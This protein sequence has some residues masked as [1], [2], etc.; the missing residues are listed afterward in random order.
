MSARA[1]LRDTFRAICPRPLFGPLRHLDALWSR[2]FADST[3]VQR[4]L[5]EDCPAWH[6]RIN[7]VLA[8][9]D[10]EAIPRVAAAGEVRGGWVVMH[11]GIEVG[12]L[13]YYGSGILQMLVRNKGVHEPQEE[14]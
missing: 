13:T 9:P 12:G 7:E 14:R 11:N 4:A 3:E 5:T 2:T 1:G 8:C 6:E 10:N